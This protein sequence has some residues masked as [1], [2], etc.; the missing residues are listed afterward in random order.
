MFLFFLFRFLFGF[1]F[2]L[3]FGLFFRN[4]RRIVAGVRFGRTFRRLG[5]GLDSDRRL[6]KF[7]DS[8]I[9]EKL[10][11]IPQDGESV[12]LEDGTILQ[13]KGIR[14][15]RIMKVLLRFHEVPGT[16]ETDA[17]AES[18]EQEH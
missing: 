14:R 13:A 7:Y 11:R 1:L 15:N 8:L 12:T 9:I 16:E 18:G 4:G 6:P 5:F 2:F 10:E 17:D 3:R